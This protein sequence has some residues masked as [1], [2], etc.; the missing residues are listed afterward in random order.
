MIKK[1]NSTDMEKINWESLSISQGKLYAIKLII[2]IVYGIIVYYILQ[3][4]ILRE[5]DYHHH[6]IGGILN[7]L[8]FFGGF[9]AIFIG[10]QYVLLS[11][12]EETEEWKK[13]KRI[14][15]ANFGTA[16]FL[17]IISAALTYT[18]NIW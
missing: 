5:I 9:T 6:L 2:A 17:F 8:I 3:Y 10:V 4:S 16:L 11:I 14:I 15:Y 7:V 12:S 1:M 18:I 13:N